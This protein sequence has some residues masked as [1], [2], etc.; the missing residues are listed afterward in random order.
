MLGESLEE[1]DCDEEFEED[2]DGLSDEDGD[3]EDEFED[4]AE[5]L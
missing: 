2:S 5:G 1:G 3:M 4:E